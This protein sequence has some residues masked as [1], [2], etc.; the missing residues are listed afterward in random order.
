VGPQRGS[1]EPGAVQR[2]CARP[3]TPGEGSRGRR[4]RNRARLQGK[5]GNQH[6]Q[7]CCASTRAVYSTHLDGGS[8]AR[9]GRCRS[10]NGILGSSFDS[11]ARAGFLLQLERDDG[12]G[13]IEERPAGKGDVVKGPF[14]P[15]NTEYLEKRVEWDEFKSRLQ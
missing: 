9:R 11:V 15:N 8:N 12:H 10:A 5:W 13:S 14:D 6:K 1:R 3:G 2:G 7:H 4:S